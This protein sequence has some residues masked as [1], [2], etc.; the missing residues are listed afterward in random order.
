MSHKPFPL[1][2][3][4]LFAMQLPSAL[5]AELRLEGVNILGASRSAYI[6]IDGES[7]RFRQG[8]TMNG[9]RL[10][11]VSPRSVTLRTPEGEEMVLTLNGEGSSEKRAGDTPVV[12][13]AKPPVKKEKRPSPYGPPGSNYN[14]QVIDDR[15]VPPGYRKVKTP[16]GDRLVEK[17]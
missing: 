17:K 12:S 14:P 3:S 11:K 13:E 1:L 4:L 6:A 8:D 15:D 10:D 5:S 7:A 16:F 2:L 9:W